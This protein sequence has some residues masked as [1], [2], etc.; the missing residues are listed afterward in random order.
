MSRATGDPQHREHSGAD[1]EPEVVRPGRPDL[2]LDHVPDVDNV[3]A[4]QGGDIGEGAD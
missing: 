3:H 4:D 2:D 1:D